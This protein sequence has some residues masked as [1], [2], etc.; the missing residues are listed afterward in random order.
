MDIPAVYY[1]T[2]KQVQEKHSPWQVH[3]MI[4]NIEVLFLD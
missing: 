3:K 2:D 4:I 1:V